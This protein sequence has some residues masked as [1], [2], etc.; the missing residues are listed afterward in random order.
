M[1]LLTSFDTHQNLTWDHIAEMKLPFKV[2]IEIY[3]YSGLGLLALVIFA[4]TEGD[5]QATAW[6][7][8]LYKL[9]M[10]M[11]S[12]ARK[13]SEARPAPNDRRGCANTAFFR[14]TGRCVRP[15]SI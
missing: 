1:Q 5:D 3:S 4:L 10:M 6:D 13:K 7:R 12:G 15:L 14:H 2:M 8:P 9:I 11:V